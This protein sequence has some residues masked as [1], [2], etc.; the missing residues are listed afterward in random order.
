MTSDSDE[1]FREIED[2]RPRG[3][4][5]RFRRLTIGSIRKS[6]GWREVR[7]RTVSGPAMGV[8]RCAQLVPEWT[9]LGQGVSSK[10]AG[11]LIT[12][13]HLEGVEIPANLRIND[14][15]QQYREDCRKMGCERPYHHFAFGQS[16]FS[17]PR[18]VVEALK[19][20]ASDHSYLPTA[21]LPAL[22]ES[23]ARYYRHHFRLETTPD[24]VV[25]SP[26]SKEMIAILLAALEG[27]ALV[28]IPSWVS[29]LPQARIL[30]KQ[31]VPLRVHADTGFKL[32]PEVLRD[33]V[34]GSGAKPSVLILNNP[35]NPTGAVYERGEL[36]ALAETCRSNGVVVIADEIYA[37]T[38]FDRKSFASMGEVYPEGSVVTGGLSK[39][40]SSGG[41]RL[42]V[43]VFPA[44]ER[45][46]IESV[47]KIAGST[48]SCVAAPIQ[49]AALKGYSLDDDVEAHVRDCSA[50][51]A[52]VGEQ[53]SSM[54]SAHGAETCVPRGSFYL[55][56]DWG[57]DAERFLRFGLDSSAKVAEHVLQV[58]HT[59]M[60]PGDA[61][62]LDE[63]EIA[64]RCS[65]VDYDGDRALEDWRRR[66]PSSS[67]EREDFV[68]RNCP[69]LTDGV[70]Y[71]GRYLEQVRAGNEPQHL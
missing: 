34:A 28:P 39:D 19:E 48:Y 26:G 43:G 17:P 7:V 6:I 33:G 27:P 55:F 46:L 56:V 1:K 4:H 71:L 64:F 8:A 63:S 22:R 70:S 12:E 15:I 45:R 60:L 51:N 57:H 44:R 58:E 30:R 3:E 21:G 59:A 49:Q 16:P 36:E 24:R 52:L 50:V 61:L 18:G 29:Y 32:T 2:L 35:H 41:Y 10:G 9:S 37:L 66:R 20:H 67:S 54:F 53:M 11:A 65:F 25:V 40:R 38:A 13:A 62:L 69:L 5:D 68:R 14:Q 47:L 23:V 31:V 42:G